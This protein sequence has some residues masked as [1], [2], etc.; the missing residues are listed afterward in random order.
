MDDGL[1]ADEWLA[2]P[3]LCDEREQAM[4]DPVPLAGA[5]RQMT[6]RDGNAEFVGQ[7]LQL[8]L[9]K[10]NADTVAAATIGG[11]QKFCRVRVARGP[12]FATSA[13]WS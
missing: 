11:D 2:A 3:V 10:A 9:P 7:V 13:E 8:A 4:L 1:V 5:R 12:S 6:D